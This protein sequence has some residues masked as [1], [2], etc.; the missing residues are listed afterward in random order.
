MSIIIKR[1]D[2]RNCIKAF[3]KDSHGE[4]IDLSDCVV[5]FHMAPITLP[6]IINRSVHVQD[7]TNG[8]VWVVWKPGE[9]DIAG[10]YQAEFKVLYKDGRKETFPNDGYIS[11]KILEDLG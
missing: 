3:L 10:T 5:T 9:T 4:P 11:I 7:R 6:A 2:T 1:G 8:E